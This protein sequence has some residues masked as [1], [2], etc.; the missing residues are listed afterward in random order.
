[1]TQYSELLILR[2]EIARATWREQVIDG[3]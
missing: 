3:K 2:S 1:M